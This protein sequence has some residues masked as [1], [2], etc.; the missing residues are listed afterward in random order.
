MPTYCFECPQCGA[1]LVAVMPIAHRDG[2][3]PCPGCEQPSL[4]RKFCAP[5]AVWTRGHPTPSQVDARLAA[6]YRP[7]RPPALTWKG[8]LNVSGSNPGVPFMVVED[9]R[10]DLGVA[11]RGAPNF[12]KGNNVDLR[13]DGFSHDVRE[14]DKKAE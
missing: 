3:F 4:I 8:N 11:V 12:L 14:P 9:A 13:L 10:V 1:R 7:E 2:D 5:R 6:N